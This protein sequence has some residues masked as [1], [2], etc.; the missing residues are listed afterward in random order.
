MCIVM[1]SKHKAISP[2][3]SHC[4][5]VYFH[6]LICCTTV[7]WKWSKSW[8]LTCFQTPRVCLMWNIM[9]VEGMW[10][11]DAQVK[12][13]PS[14]S[15]FAESASYKW[16]STF[17]KEF[18]LHFAEI[19]ISAN[20]SSFLSKFSPKLFSKERLGLCIFV[21]SAATFK[22]NNNISMFKYWISQITKFYWFRSCVIHCARFI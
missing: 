11:L 9:L 10:E 12:E 6:F 21:I 17:I 19:I 22:S 4:N 20:F 2:L 13:V 15:D 16:V 1:A 3:S 14:H 7:E 5:V 18:F 8:S